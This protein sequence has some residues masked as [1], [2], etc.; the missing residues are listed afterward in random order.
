[1]GTA[2]DNFG[3]I[4]SHEHGG[5]S[6]SL[7]VKF[8]SSI[9]AIWAIGPSFVGTPADNMIVEIFKRLV[10]QASGV[11]LVDSN[12][13]LGQGELKQGLMS[14]KQNAFQ[15]MGS[16]KKCRRW[17]AHGFFT[18]TLLQAMSKD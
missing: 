9:F 12:H 5:V 3:K 11:I 6:V 17:I 16:D 15:A 1:M 10:L 7:A 8:D 2:N 18:A 13:C 14:S 4:K